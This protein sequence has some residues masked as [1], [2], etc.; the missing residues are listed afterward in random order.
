MLTSWEVQF[1]EFYYDED[2]LSYNKIGDK[3]NIP[4]FK[5]YKKSQI[6]QLNWSDSWDKKI[7]VENKYID[8]YIKNNSFNKTEFLTQLNKD[9]PKLEKLTKYCREFYF[10]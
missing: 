3:F 1:R 7:E 5:N 8:L 9:L 6:L 2:I 4:E 10:W